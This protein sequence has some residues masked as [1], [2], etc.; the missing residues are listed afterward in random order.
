MSTLRCAILLLALSLTLAPLPGTADVTVVECEFRGSGGN[1]ADG[2]IY[3]QR[4]PANTLGTVTL[5]YWAKKAQSVEMK[6]TVRDS[7]FDGELIGEVVVAFDLEARVQRKVTFDFGGAPV[8]RGSRITF[9]QTLEVISVVPGD[10]QDE[11]VFFD[12]GGRSDGPLCAGVI[13]TLGT[14]PPLSGDR[15]L[16]VG[17]IVTAKEPGP[18]LLSNSEFDDADGL[19]DWPENFSNDTVWS[20]FDS[21]GDEASGSALVDN[22]ADANIASGLRSSCLPVTPGALYD[23]SAWI[24]EPSQAE[25]GR[26]SFV[27]FWFRSDTC[28]AG[29]FQRAEGIGAVDPPDAEWTHISGQLTALDATES[30]KVTAGSASNSPDPGD[31]RMYIDSVLFA[32][33]PGGL[34]PSAAALVSL[35]ALSRRRV[36]LAGQNASRPPAARA[37]PHA[38]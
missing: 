12:I 35:A 23:L 30:A 32:P 10:E 6:L 25:T 22:S 37:Q 27:V 13:E 8:A 18:N 11:R 29:T 21:L 14:I 4:Y 33:E 28:A 38:L 34:A 26:S 2:G 15:G 5:G 9:A 31:Y 16:G 19:S 24:Y 36:R 3:I 20:D 17:I 1:L 7:A